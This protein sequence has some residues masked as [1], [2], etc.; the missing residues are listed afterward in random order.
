MCDTMLLVGMCVMMPASIMHLAV[1]SMQLPKRKVL[2]CHL[3]THM[4]SH[5]PYMKLAVLQFFLWA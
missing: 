4:P 2:I 5:V 3:H 1:V